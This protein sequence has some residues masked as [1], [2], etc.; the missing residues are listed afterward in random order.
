MIIAVIKYRPS[1]IPAWSLVCKHTIGM[2]ITSGVGDM[3]KKKRN[4]YIFFR[5]N[6]LWDGPRRCITRYISEIK[7]RFGFTAVFGGAEPRI[8]S[9]DDAAPERP[10]FLPANTI[11]SS[12]TRCSQKAIK[13]DGRRAPQ[14]GRRKLRS[15]D[16]ASRSRETAAGSRETGSKPS[17]ARKNRMHSNR[18]F[19]TTYMRACERRRLRSRPFVR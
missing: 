15:P 8:C 11:F 1:C 19:R 10:L 6:K 13:T 4:R 16:V 9:S 3:K 12:R 18:S 2:A 17:K 7:F 14:T 5:V